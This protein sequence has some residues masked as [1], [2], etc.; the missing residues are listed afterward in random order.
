MGLRL[1]EGI[2]AA[3]F[4]ARTGMALE[5]ALDAGVLERALEAGYLTYDDR[6]LT[7]TTEGRLRLDS[8][9]TQLVN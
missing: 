6:R 7:A 2:D 8:L 4:A 1:T 5:A 9:L 3:R